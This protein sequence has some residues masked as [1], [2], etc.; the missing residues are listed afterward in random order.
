MT[1][2]IL[3]E[4]VGVDLVRRE[5]WAC[6]VIPPFRPVPLL[7]YYGRG[8]LGFVGAPLVLGLG[9]LGFVGAPLVFVDATFVFGLGKLG[10]VG[11]PLEYAIAQFTARMPTIVRINE[12]N[13]RA[14][15]LIM[16][17]WMMRLL[18]LVGPDGE[19]SLRY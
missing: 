9:K 16:S 2:P 15:R 18:I 19:Y 1:S 12:R 4:L 7:A 5:R 8:K 3:T 13:L 17:P 6:P 14:L 10:F 11:A